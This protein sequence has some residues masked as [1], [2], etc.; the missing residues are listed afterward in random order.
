MVAYNICKNQERE[1]RKRKI[2]AHKEDMGL[3]S[4][5]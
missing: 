3:K 2:K 5:G 4:F 1:E